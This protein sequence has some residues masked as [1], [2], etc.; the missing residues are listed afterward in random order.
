V[1]LVL[2]AGST[3]RMVGV[4]FTPRTLGVVAT[5]FGDYGGAPVAGGRLGDRA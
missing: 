4:G 3:L 1:G 5:R 2:G